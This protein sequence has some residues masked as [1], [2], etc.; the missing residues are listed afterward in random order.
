MDRKQ[1]DEFLQATLVDLRLSRAERQALHTLIEELA[2][3][4]H[5]LNQLRNRAFALAGERASSAPDRLLIDWL[6]ELVRVVDAQRG[7]LPEARHS[8][9]LFSPGRACLDR[10]V[11]L[12]SAAR[13]TIDACVYTITDDRLSGPLIAAHRRGVKVRIIT[14]DSKVWDLGSDIERLD[15]TGMSVEDD[16]APG[17]M[18]HKFAIFDDR[19]LATGSY[20]WTRSAASANQENLIVTSHAPLVADFAREFARLWKAWGQP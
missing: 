20:N 5:D 7:A 3:G 8:E 13:M 18:H 4:P 9:A 14:E 15:S 11:G 12:I 1:I 17:L 10:L 6:R 2:Q 19:T 16:N